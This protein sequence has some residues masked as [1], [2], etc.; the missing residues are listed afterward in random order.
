MMKF[1][2]EKL[3]L[4]NGR[5]VNLDKISCMLLIVIFYGLCILTSFSLLKLESHWDATISR[6][7]GDEGLRYEATFCHFSHYSH[8]GLRD[9]H[10]YSL[11]YIDDTRTTVV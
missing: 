4:T 7:V 3:F 5:Y 8:T 2:S 9:Y 6:L 11:N 10:I 1:D